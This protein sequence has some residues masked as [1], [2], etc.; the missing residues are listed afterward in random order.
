MATIP[1]IHYS[2]SRTGGAVTV[3]ATLADHLSKYHNIKIYTTKHP[4]IDKINEMYDTSL[5]VDQF[6]VVT[7]GGM[8]LARLSKGWTA[9][10]MTP[11]RDITNIRYVLFHELARR[12]IH[13]HN[14]ELVIGTYAEFYSPWPTFQYL[15]V[16][17]YNRQM[18]PE[19]K[20]ENSLV[21]KVIS[22]VIQRLD[23]PAYD[24]ADQIV[25]TNSK[26]SQRQ[27][28]AAHK[29]CDGV[30]HPPVASRRMA[31]NRIEWSERDFGFVMAGRLAPDKRQLAGIETITELRDRGHNVHLHI[32]GPAASG[33]YA[34]RV[35]DTAKKRDF[36]TYEGVLPRDEYIR[37]LEEHR[38]GLHM[39]EREH[40]GIVVAEMVAAG[41]IPFVPNS[42]GQT[43]IVN[44][45]PDILF[46]KNPTDRIEKVLQSDSKNN[47]RRSLRENLHRY[48]REQF[49][50]KCE[51]HISKIL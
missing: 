15:H 35:I 40:F 28:E 6:E 39:K 16:P 43:E 41:M 45:N 29:Q 22:P 24:K 42:G 44:E 25:V 31:S 37:L 17:I 21:A 7:L 47:I 2:L 5:T 32:C 38:F 8:P 36:V 30:V 46:E 20:V 23:G 51:E 4:P 14:P 11:F 26:W 1:F 33:P 48:T 10:S 13:D 49:I 27:I 18:C 3:C 12:R 34:E 9:L 19:L 50:S